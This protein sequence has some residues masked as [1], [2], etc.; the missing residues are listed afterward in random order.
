MINDCVSIIAKHPEIPVGGRLSLFLQEWEKITSD[1]WV[2]NT[3]KTGYK[4]EFLVKPP[5]QG[6]KATNVPLENQDVIKQE[7]NSLLEKKAI[8]V[9]PFS[10]IHSGF[11]STL[12][13]V[14]KKTGDLRPVINLKALNR[15]LRKQHFKMDTLSKVINLVGK[16]DWGITIDLKDA[17]FHIKIFREHRQFLRFQFQGTVYQFR[18]L[19]FGPTSAPRVFVKIISV[20]VAFLRKFN[21]RLASYLDDW[22]AVNSTKVLLLKDRALVLNLLYRL[23]FIVNKSKSQLIPIQK[24]IYLGSLF[25][26]NKGLVFPTQERIEKIKMATKVIC[27][28]HCTAKQFMVLLGLIASCLELVPNAR[29]YMRPIQ[30]HLLQHWSPARMPMSTII[31]VTAKLKSCL[32]WWLQDQNIAKGRSL[33]RQSFLVTLTTDASGTWGWGGHLY[34]L[35]CQGKWTNL[36]KMLHI[37]CLE[38]M[39]VTQSLRHF[40]CHLN[41]KMS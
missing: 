21:V 39:A 25:D 10:Q 2:L 13:L 16:G 20:V 4:L 17:Y 36:Q 41:G 22:L 40:L 1:K 6:V 29:L 18:V 30:L 35:T 31:P 33:Q 28:G 37:N 34:N 32:L 8:E 14:P 27:K 11:Y 24:I 15:Y 19:C 26:L 23:G 3:I 9:V 38:M 7:I 5:F 12:F